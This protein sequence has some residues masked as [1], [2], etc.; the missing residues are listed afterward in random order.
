[1]VNELICKIDNLRLLQFDIR[2]GLPCSHLMFTLASVSVEG[3]NLSMIS[4]NALG[5]SG[6]IV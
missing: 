5:V 6:K 2:R 4:L 1:M 3:E